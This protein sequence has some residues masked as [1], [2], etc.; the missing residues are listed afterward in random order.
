MTFSAD[1]NAFASGENLEVIGEGREEY[2]LIG[3]SQKRKCTSAKEGVV[4]ADKEGRGRAFWNER[5]NQDR[6]TW[7]EEISLIKENIKE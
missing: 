6:A 7:N 2:I 1:E 3:S 4:D 5:K